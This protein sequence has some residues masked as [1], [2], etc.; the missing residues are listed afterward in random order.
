M[1]KIL[2]GPIFRFKRLSRSKKLIKNADL[3]ILD[4][5]AYKNPSLTHQSF[6]EILRLVKELN[7][8][9]VYLTQVGIAWP[10]YEMAQ[11][12]VSKQAKNIF[13]AYD[14]LKIKI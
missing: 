11:K 4:C 3:A 12:I 6:P 2:S 9:K 7:F 8:K 13:L 5:A 1:L 10:H 14:G